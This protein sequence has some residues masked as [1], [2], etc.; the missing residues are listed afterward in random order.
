MAACDGESMCLRGC[1]SSSRRCYHRCF[2]TMR[3]RRDGAGY[4]ETSHA[5]RGQARNGW[6]VLGEGDGLEIAPSSYQPL[7]TAT[8]DAPCDQ[9]S[10]CLTSVRFGL[11]SPR[12]PHRVRGGDA[13]SHGA[14]TGRGGGPAGVYH[15][16][17]WNSVRTYVP[18]TRGY[19]FQNHSVPFV[20][21]SRMAPSQ[22]G[23]NRDLVS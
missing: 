21:F 13:E 18:F 23:A 3:K 8:L 22:A 5:I 12:E 4:R 20:P 15:V 10:N 14:W 17:R 7:V 9:P 1:G 11:A 19:A 16:C 6:Q 2:E